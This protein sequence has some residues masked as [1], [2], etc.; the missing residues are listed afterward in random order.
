MKKVSGE[1]NA[2]VKFLLRCLHCYLHCFER[3]IRFLNRNAYIQISITGKNFCFAAKDA[4]FLILRNPAKFAIVGGIGNI[5]L[6]FGKF[7]IVFGATCISYLIL[8]RVSYFSDDIQSPIIP[9]VIFILISYAIGVV[10]MCV[11]SMSVDTVL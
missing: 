10:F 8:T 11:Y 6:F 7:F 4:F 2:A 3:F 9:T 1:P 5:F